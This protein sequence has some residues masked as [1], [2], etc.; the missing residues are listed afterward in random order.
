M[1]R[2]ANQVALALV[3]VLGLS[4]FAAAGATGTLPPTANCAT[5][6]VGSHGPAV[7]TVQSAMHAT[8]D[9]DFGPLTAKAVRRFQR[10]HHLRRTAAVDA[11]TWAKLPAPVAAAACGQPVSGN[12]VTSSCTTLSVGAVGPAVA[13]LQRRLHITADGQFG[14][15]TRRAVV[16][17]QRRLKAAVSG[18]VDAATW[19]ALG[20]TGTPA[21]V[22]VDSTVKAS[23]TTP[24]PAPTPTTTKTPAPAPPPPPADAA[25]QAKVR[26]QVLALAAKLP[27]I[28]GTSTNPVALQAMNFAVA[29][30]GK[31]YKWAGVGPASYDCSGLTMTSYRNAGITTP[32]VAAD[33]YG[34]GAPVP[35][36]QVQQGD[37]LFYAMDLTKPA[38][39]YH[40]VM[41]AG[42]GKI[43][44]A[45]YTGAFVGTRPLWTQG[46]LPVAWRPTG[47]LSLPVRSGATGWTVAQLQTALDR[48]GATLTI[49]GGFGTATLAAVKAW[50]TAHKLP[51]TGV[52]DVATWLT[53]R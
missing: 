6:A 17:A 9:G 26:A 12:G 18:V 23:A 43:V 10:A 40:V 27:A 44:D 3:A 50:Q 14:P 13:V 22:A 36:D 1:R 28:P 38:T 8:A 39:I 4:S 49:D 24:A 42:A 20:L 21:C 52:V 48:G 53:L 19:A 31:P 32:R 29:Q 47:L 7:A 25:E 45:P 46:L 41:Y 16:T 33:Q 5:L 37:L 11:A 2:V 34:F 51:V 15:Q 30:T 35:L